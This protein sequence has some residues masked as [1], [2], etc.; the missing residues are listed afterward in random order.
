MCNSWT[1][2]KAIDR[3]RIINLSLAGPHDLLLERLIRRAVAANIVVVAS[4]NNA[5]LTE[6]G[7]PASLNEVIAVVSDHSH[8]LQPG[9]APSAHRRVL[10]VPGKEIL[11]AMP[12]DRYDFVTGSSLATAHV[13]GVIALM[14]ARNTDLTVAEIHELLGTPAVPASATAGPIRIDACDVFARML[15]RRICADPQAQTVIG[16]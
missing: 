5:R 11:T 1:L 16:K 13:T 4:V 8:L 9:S 3:A 2:V 14:L 6:S 10:A 7:F 15:N 12:N